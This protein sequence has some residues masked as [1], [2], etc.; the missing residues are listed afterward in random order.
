MSAPHS[1]PWSRIGT[2]ALVEKPNRLAIRGHWPDMRAQVVDARRAARSPD[3]MDGA[4]AAAGGAHPDLEVRRGAVEGHDLARAVG[5]HEAQDHAELDAGQPGRLDGDSLE[6]GVRRRLLCGELGDASQRGLL[7]GERLQVGA[8]LAVGQRRG[9]QL[10]E[11]LQPV[12][13]TGGQRRS[14]GGGGQHSPHLGFDGD[15]CRDGCRAARRSRRA[16]CPRSRV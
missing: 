5:R 9:D 1:A 4:V 15:R 3:A 12:F 10:G 7:V 6:H 2:P 8:R 16:R 13:G 14:A 11:L